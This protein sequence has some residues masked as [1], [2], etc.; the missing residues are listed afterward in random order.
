MIYKDQGNQR[1][2]VSQAPPEPEKEDPVRYGDGEQP[3]REPEAR[4]VYHQ[5]R[6]R[7]ERRCREQPVE[8][9]RWTPGQ[10]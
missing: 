8:G 4:K 2:G 9:Y 6:D 1:R 10:C 3:R 5:K 7:R